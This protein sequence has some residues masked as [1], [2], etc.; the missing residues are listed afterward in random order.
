[1]RLKVMQNYKIDP[2][3]FILVILTKKEYF[4]D[5]N[6]K[7]N[8]NSSK[9]IKLLYNFNYIIIINIQ[10]YSETGI[11]LIKPCLPARS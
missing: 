10:K 6:K 5:R 3:I 2:I 8:E 7:I 1:M 9:N 4:I 11:L